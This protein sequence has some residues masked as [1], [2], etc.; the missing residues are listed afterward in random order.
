MRGQLRERLE[1]IAR[2]QH[3]ERALRESRTE[4][5]SDVRLVVDDKNACPPDG[6]VGVCR[7]TSA[8]ICAR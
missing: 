1:A 2:D 4:Y 6:G 8:A 7:Q 5:E 3:V